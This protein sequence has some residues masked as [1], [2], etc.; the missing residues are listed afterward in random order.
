MITSLDA[1]ADLDVSAGLCIVGA[2]PAGLEVARFFNDSTVSVVVLEGGDFEYDLKTQGLHR[3]VCVGKKIRSFADEFNPHLP[4]EVRSESRIRQFGG[5][6]NV[7]SGKWKALTPDDFEAKAWIPHSG[8]PLNYNEFLPYYREVVKDYGLPQSLLDSEASRPHGRRGAV[9]EALRRSISY[10]QSPPLDFNGVFRR[11]LEDSQ[12]VTVI[13]N[14]NVTGLVMDAVASRVSHVVA[15]SLEGKEIHVHAETF[16]LAAGSLENARLL[17]VLRDRRGRAAGHDLDLVGRFYMDHPKVKR[18]RLV[19]AHPLRLKHFLAPRKREQGTAIGFRL[20][21]ALRQRASLP[22]HSTELL[23]ASAPD[24]WSASRAAMRAAWNGRRWS[25]LLRLFAFT[26]SWSP[27]RAFRWLLF[28]YLGLASQY[29]LVHHLEQLP[30]PESHVYLSSGETDAL[31]EPVLVVDWELT[32]RD[33]ALFKTYLENLQAEISRHQIGQVTYPAR[34]VDLESLADAA[35]HM[36]V[37]RMGSSSGNGVVDKDCKVFGIPNLYVAGSAVFPTAG[38]A[39]PMLT[40]LALSRRLS[41]HLSQMM[42]GGG[43]ESSLA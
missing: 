33:R 35:H 8:W 30:N 32:E 26:L 28:R 39:N 18:G 3:I 34:E 27:R 41:H 31:G 9:A 7:W 21:P 11:T 4:P 6:S 37:I 42:G 5:T 12:N 2:G 10:K 24:D 36:G 16:V 19:P 22:N 38:N 23:P 17:L 13:L 43:K 14:A 20:S 25:T 29:E 40:I 1:L 15:R